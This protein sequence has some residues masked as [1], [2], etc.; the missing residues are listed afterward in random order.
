MFSKKDFHSGALKDSYLK[1]LYTYLC[2]N[3]PYEIANHIFRHREKVI[4]VLKNPINYD[5]I[6]DIIKDS[7]D[8]FLPKRI[9]PI[10]YGIPVICRNRYEYY[11]KCFCEKI[12]Q[13]KR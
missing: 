5:Y 4:R 10:N 9:Q 3:I 13:V 1:Y 7:C 2:G 12:E 8:D 11:R 6:P